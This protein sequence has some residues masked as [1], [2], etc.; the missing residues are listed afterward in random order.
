[1]SYRVVEIKTKTDHC[2]TFY[3]SLK[4]FVSR[5][6]SKRQIKHEENVIKDFA[7]RPFGKFLKTFTGQTLNTVVFM[8]EWHLY[9]SAL[10]KSCFFFLTKVS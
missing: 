4:D 6:Q 7:F 8:C 3:F 5:S 10:S 2:V 1:M 9:V